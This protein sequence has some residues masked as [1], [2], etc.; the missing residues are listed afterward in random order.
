MLEFLGIILALGSPL[1]YGEEKTGRFLKL[2][3][4]MQT[5]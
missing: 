2:L 5:F 1:N 4:N 3:N